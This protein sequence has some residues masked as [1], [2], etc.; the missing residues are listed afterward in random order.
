MERFHSPDDVP[1]SGIL[2]QAARLMDLFPTF[3]ETR[4]ECDERED[5]GGKAYCR[6]RIH[7]GGDMCW[8]EGVGS[9]LFCEM[10]WNRIWGAGSAARDSWHK[11]GCS[12]LMRCASGSSCMALKTIRSAEP[13]ILGSM[14]SVT[15][16]ENVSYNLPET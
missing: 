5:A 6:D 11:A 12:Q 9:C 4:T 3:D 2:F 8:A 14:R 10:K 15:L 7:S 1:Q 16:T 13:S